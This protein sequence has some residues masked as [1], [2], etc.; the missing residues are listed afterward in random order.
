[1]AEILRD[2]THSDAMRLLA[3]DIALTQQ[4]QIGMMQGWLDV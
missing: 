3:S 1:M 4:A 2:K